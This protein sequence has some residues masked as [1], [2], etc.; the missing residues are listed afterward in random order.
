M[1]KSRLLTVAGAAQVE[2][3]GVPSPSCFPFHRTSPFG[4]IN[5]KV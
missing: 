1:R 5:S 2:R 3:A 4:T